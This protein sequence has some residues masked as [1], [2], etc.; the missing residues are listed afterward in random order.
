M[1][2]NPMTRVNWDE[3]KRTV[4]CHRA[5]HP[6]WENSRLS[7]DITGNKGN[8]MAVSGAV[9]SLPANIPGVGTLVT[10]VAGTTI[11]LG[12]LMKLLADLVAEISL[13][14]GRRPSSATSREGFWV[15]CSAF[16]ATTGGEAVSKYV[17]MQ[18]SKRAFKRLVQRLLAAIGVRVT[19]K[20]IARY[21]PLIGS[22]VMAAIN[23][24]TANMVGRHAVKYYED[25]PIQDPGWEGPAKDA[26]DDE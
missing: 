6:E 8:W 24:A 25:N 3:R 4:Q 26:D 20:T 15:L 7:K 16:G 2:L 5:Q 19:Q 18:A 14:Y 12:V 1:D 22:G 23:K 21:I 10:I 17:V 9:T 13:V 11:D